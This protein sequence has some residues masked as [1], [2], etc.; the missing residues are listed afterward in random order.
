MPRNRYFWRTYSTYASTYIFPTA[1]ESSE[2]RHHHSFYSFTLNTNRFTWP[3]GDHVRCWCLFT[4]IDVPMPC[5]LSI[6]PNLD[7]AEARCEGY[8]MTS[9]YN[10]GWVSDW[11]QRKKCLKTQVRGCRLHDNLL[12][13]WKIRTTQFFG[14]R[15]FI[16]SFPSYLHSLITRLASCAYQ[17]LISNVARLTTSTTVLQ[18]IQDNPR[19][20][21]TH[22]LCDISPA[23][24]IDHCVVSWIFAINWSGKCIQSLCMAQNKL[25]Q[26]DESFRPCVSAFRSWF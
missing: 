16:R 24:I 18:S 2:P 4:T 7:P 14:L 26:W 12:P 23:P 21:T 15:F 5:G 17:D 20:V 19:A 9:W 13:Q 1:L 11:S 8:I 25:R 22:R 6:D 3:L 10:K